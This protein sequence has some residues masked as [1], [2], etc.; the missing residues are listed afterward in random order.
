MEPS[1]SHDQIRPHPPPP[2]TQPPTKEKSLWSSTQEADRALN[3]QMQ[4]DHLAH[5]RRTTVRIAKSRSPKIVNKIVPKPPIDG[6]EKTQ[7]KSLISRKIGGNPAPWRKDSNFQRELE[8]LAKEPEVEDNNSDDDS[9]EELNQEQMHPCII[10]QFVGVPICILLL[11][12]ALSLSTTVLLLHPSMD[13][14]LSLL[15]QQ[16]SF[17]SASESR[18]VAWHGL[19]AAFA[20]Q[21]AQR[22][23]LHS[24]E[25][26]SSPIN[27]VAS[28][29]NRSS[30]SV[31]FLHATNHSDW[32]G[33]YPAMHS[34]DPSKCRENG[35]F[36]V[37]CRAG[38]HH[39]SCADGYVLAWKSTCDS[40]GSC[41]YTCTP[42]VH[43]VSAQTDN[44]NVNLLRSIVANT[45]RIHPWL[46]A[47]S[48]VRDDS[49][50]RLFYVLKAGA[51]GIGDSPYHVVTANEMRVPLEARMI[52]DWRKE[53]ATGVTGEVAVEIQEFEDVEREGRKQH[54]VVATKGGSATTINAAKRCCEE[55]VCGAGEFRS[56]LSACTNVSSS[57]NGEETRVRPSLKAGSSSERVFVYR[58]QEYL[59]MLTLVFFVV[60]A[61]VICFVLLLALQGTIVRHESETAVSLTT[62]VC[63]MLTL[64]TAISQTSNHLQS[65]V[66]D[67]AMLQASSLRDQVK[68]EMNKLTHVM[69]LLSERDV[70][71]NAVR[72]GT[73]M[74]IATMAAMDSSVA[75]GLVYYGEEATGNF[76][77]AKV[78]VPM[79]FVQSNANTSFRTTEYEVAEE[80]SVAINGVKA[81]HRFVN[82]SSRLSGGN[83]VDQYDPRI[84]PWYKYAMEH[85]ANGSNTAVWSDIYPFFGGATL[86]EGLGITLCKVL[87]GRKGV[88]AIDF[89]LDSIS[90]L[91]KQKLLELGKYNTTTD[92]WVSEESVFG[93]VVGVGRGE[94]STNLQRLNP[95]EIKTIEGA[96]KAVKRA[97]ISHTEESHIRFGNGVD[98][99][100]ITT[101][102]IDGGELSSNLDWRLVQTTQFQEFVREV[103][104][105]G[106]AALLIGIVISVA[107]AFATRCGGTMISHN[108]SDKLKSNRATAE[109]NAAKL[110]V[111]V[112]HEAFLAT[113]TMSPGNLHL[114]T[115]KML[116]CSL[117]K[118]SHV[119][120]VWST[121]CSLRASQIPHIAM[122]HANC[123]D[124]DSMWHWVV[125]L[126][127]IA[128][129]L[130][131]FYDSPRHRIDTFWTVCI[132]QG[133][134]ILVEIVDVAVRI[135]LDCHLKERHGCCGWSGALQPQSLRVDEA[136]LKLR[137]SLRVI[138][139]SVLIV[140][141][142]Y[143][144]IIFTAGS[145]PTDGFTVWSA[146]LRAMIVVL[147]QDDLI[148]ALVT[149]IATVWKAK[150][151]F[152]LGLQFLIVVNTIVLSILQNSYNDAKQIGRGLRSFEGSLITMFVYVFSADNF[153]DL[154]YGHKEH[155]TAGDLWYSLLFLIVILIGMFLFLSI[156]LSV[157]QTEFTDRF[158]TRE[159]NRVKEREEGH[160]IVFVCLCRQEAKTRTSVMSRQLSQQ[161][162]RLSTMVAVGDVKHIKSQGLQ[163]KVSKAIIIDT[164][165]AL[166]GSN[167]RIAQRAVAASTTSN[168][169]LNFE[170]FHA[171]AEEL[172]AELGNF[173]TKGTC[174]CRK[175]SFRQLIRIL[176]FRNSQVLPQSARQSDEKKDGVNVVGDGDGA[177]TTKADNTWI[178]ETIWYRWLKLFLIFSNAWMVC[179]LATERGSDRHLHFYM[180]MTYVLLHTVDVCTNISLRGFTKYL[181]VGALRP[182]VSDLANRGDVVVV[183]AAFIVFLISYV[184]LYVES[185][186]ALVSNATQVLLRS[187]TPE[188]IALALPNLRIFTTVTTT[189]HLSFGLL[190]LMTKEQISDLFLLLFLFLYIFGVIGCSLFANKFKLLASDGKVH[191]AANFDDLSKTLRTMFHMLLGEY[192]D[193]MFAGVDSYGSLWPA[194]YFISFAIIMTLIFTNLV[195]GVVCDLYLSE[196]Y[197]PMLSTSQGNEGDE[198]NKQ[199]GVV[200]AGLTTDRNDEESGTHSETKEY[201]LSLNAALQE[202]NMR[203]IA[204]LRMTKMKRALPHILRVRKCKTLTKK[205]TFE[206]SE[207]I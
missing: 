112:R 83:L 62:F 156:L 78:G 29:V 66:S 144:V 207:F 181:G 31:Y 95:T 180:T 72:D 160:S 13:K 196:V 100:E 96:A 125:F 45:S 139:L 118:Y 179:F 38:L 40:F 170:D 177:M 199:D 134:C 138:A 101:R 182:T 184:P 153:Q 129:L 5:Q 28:Y 60:S 17:M 48:A 127:S 111:K 54:V 193:L 110:A 94:A 147:S 24:C 53:K 55:G 161:D 146:P 107:G 65:V 69:S 44:I 91:L 164:F 84:R 123:L 187:A 56:F 194:T 99:Q 190:A 105:E 131:S 41:D 185:N 195:V 108:F 50:D 203:L 172:R 36:D 133:V 49:T 116:T 58:D 35:H 59:L 183:A 115:Q 85:H 106:S 88:I 22:S 130:L 113:R 51:D 76:Y 136:D 14:S 188:K 119:L 79:T 57:A 114:L 68:F 19:S 82:T 174:R 61:L 152:S 97:K 3:R 42:S 137:G 10:L 191:A 197:A 122:I 89:T 102:K 166:D 15:V 124:P 141:W 117:R 37:D 104:V 67:V 2:P 18:I 27:L 189:Q 4:R 25:D 158:A 165:A 204:A 167:S 173:K 175:L 63:I 34:A 21:S 143:R 168:E 23:A 86:D 8:R 121:E 155:N 47:S 87:P 20:A 128:N 30:V 71:Q 93:H 157:F 12:V 109:K 178:F 52:E 73:L 132:V 33:A 9:K 1:P 159:Q 16:R 90:A 80:R 201:L 145:A 43:V 7:I 142:S 70:T 92:L 186:N 39:A 81:I 176:F 200:V 150:H 6:E 148:E 46:F 149:F 64:T 154:V 140:E 169:Y 103:Q 120:E 151:V 98:H 126:V 26:I 206:E 32:C 75:V 202:E 205:K 77:G 198:K 192:T 135:V 163:S 74:D 11:A 162:R 171:A